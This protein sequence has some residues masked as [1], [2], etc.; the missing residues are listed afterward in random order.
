[1]TERLPD[2]AYWHRISYEAGC[3]ATAE[4]L[5]K[6]M[7]EEREGLLDFVL[8]VRDWKGIPKVLRK[9]AEKLVGLEE[10]T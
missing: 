4:R 3:R 6:V 8:L 5:A 9:R 10:K 2:R 1:M 7:V